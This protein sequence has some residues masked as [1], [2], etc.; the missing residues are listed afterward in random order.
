M[1]NSPTTFR[2]TQA[3]PY[4][5]ADNSYK[6]EDPQPETEELTPVRI[7]PPQVRKRGRPRKNPEQ[8]QP[9]TEDTTVRTEPP[10]RRG[11]RR[12]RKNPEQQQQD[13]EESTV[14]EEPPQARRPRRPRKAKERGTQAFLTEKEK[15]DLNLARQL[16]KDGIITTPGLP[17]KESDRTEIDALIANSTFKILKYNPEVHYRRIFNLRLVQEIKGKNTQPYK[18][19]RLVLAGHSDQGKEEI[20]T[21]S[22]TIQRIS[23]RLL[24]SLGASLIATYDMHC[25]LRDITQAYVQSKDKL[26]R[27]I[28]AKPPKELQGTF[29]PGTILRVV[30]PLYRAAKSGLY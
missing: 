22:P 5:R 3:K 13:T 17:F 10:Q 30:Q 26:L 19:S 28:L 9:Y 14:Q 15:G 21:Q 29:P 27:T 18:K 16:Q 1:E 7:K 2:G 20:L 25:E 12:P 6:P 11:P 8:P 4:Y 24:L 23:Q